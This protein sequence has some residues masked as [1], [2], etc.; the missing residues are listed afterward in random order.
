M[1][2]FDLAFEDFIDFFRTDPVS[3]LTEAKVRMKSAITDDSLS[4]NERF[5]LWRLPID[6]YQI[7]PI[8]DS[9]YSKYH[10]L[11]QSFKSDQL[12]DEMFE[13]A[14]YFQVKIAPRCARLDRINL[15]SLDDH[16]LNCF[17]ETTVTITYTWLF[18]NIY[19]Y[20]TNGALFNFDE[21]ILIRQ[22][23]K[24]QFPEM[25]TAKGDLYTSTNPRHLPAG[26][27]LWFK[28]PR[29]IAFINQY[30]V[31]YRLQLLGDNTL[32]IVLKGD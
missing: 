13:I 17:N 19:D 28:M 15:R 16:M 11:K 8:Y 14:M 7:S 1:H 27:L 25:F 2:I 4:R 21:A 5:I 24:E 6:N 22:E 3:V 20:L 29:L 18:R 12:A 26:K 31:D 23:L 9:N 30:L 32:T 10:T